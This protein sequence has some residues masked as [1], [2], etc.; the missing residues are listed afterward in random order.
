MSN[1][2]TVS[3]RVDKEMKERL[4]AVA[5]RQQRSKSFVAASALADYIAMQE[6]QIAGIEE[7]IAQL[8]RGEGIEHEQVRKWISSWDT[9]SELPK[10]TA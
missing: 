8:D 7:A 1:T 9:G 4:E 2:T 6:A 10:P 3:I 5:R